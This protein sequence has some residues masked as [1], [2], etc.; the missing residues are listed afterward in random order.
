MAH[1]Q[2]VVGLRYRADWTRLSL[3]ADVLVET[4]GD[5][6]LRRARAMAPPGFRVGPVMRLRTNPDG[7]PAGMEEVPAA[8]VV[9]RTAGAV[10]ATRSFLDDLRGRR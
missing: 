10:S 1:L 4:D 5:L 3:S 8:D 9:R 6:A 7:S 2:D